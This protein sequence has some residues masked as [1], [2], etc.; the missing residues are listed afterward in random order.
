MS[1]LGPAGSPGQ[2]EIP[3]RYAVVQEGPEPKTIVTKLKWFTV[4]I[5][6]GETNVPFTQIEEQLSFRD[7][8]S[9]ATRRLC[10]L[11]WLRS[12]GDEGTGKEETCKE[13]AG[14]SSA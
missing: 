14:A 10:R 2:F 11:C 8:E 9:A 3:L 5:P 1:I 6:P 7:A 13:A 12:R 4:V